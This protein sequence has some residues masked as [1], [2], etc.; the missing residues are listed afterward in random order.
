MSSQGE[1]FKAD[2]GFGQ[3]FGREIGGFLARAGSKADVRCVGDGY[4][5]E[6]LKAP[7][8][9]HRG[10]ETKLLVEMIL[11]PEGAGSLAM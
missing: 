5:P 9:R 4:Q 11:L 1:R 6:F 2:P 3:N 10:F 8:L 7:T